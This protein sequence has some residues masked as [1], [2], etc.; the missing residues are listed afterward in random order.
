MTMTYY[1]IDIVTMY[2]NKKSASLAKTGRVSEDWVGRLH[3]YLDL[4]LQLSSTR[5]KCIQQNKNTHSHRVGFR[6]D[7]ADQHKGS[8]E[9]STVVQ[10]FYISE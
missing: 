8:Y 5:F 3:K 2:F 6:W 9:L 10:Y 1:V 7:K 4:C